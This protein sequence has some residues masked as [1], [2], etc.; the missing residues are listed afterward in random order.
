MKLL[1]IFLLC[2][3]TQINSRAICCTNCGNEGN[4]LHD[5]FEKNINPKC[6]QKQVC[7]FACINWVN[8]E[9]CQVNHYY[10]I[11]ETS[12]LWSLGYKKICLERRRTKSYDVL[13]ER[14][15]DLLEDEFPKFYHAIFIKYELDSFDKAVDYI[16]RNGKDQKRIYLFVNL[17]QLVRSVKRLCHEKDTR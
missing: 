4:V 9:N 11:P 8:D 15:G 5:E 2:F 1:F 6:L 12:R 14:V 3:L 17:V 16:K 7:R 13:W 10:E